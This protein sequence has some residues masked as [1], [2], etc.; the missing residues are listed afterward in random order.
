VALEDL[1]FDDDACCGSNQRRSRGR[2]RII[3]LPDVMIAAIAVRKSLPT[4]TGNLNAFRVGAF[5]RLSADDENWWNTQT[6]ARLRD[7]SPAFRAMPGQPTGRLGGP[8]SGRSRPG[9]FVAISG[10]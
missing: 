5:G 3:G 9:N 10:S 4:V 8:G 1:P 7:S 2:V 6:S